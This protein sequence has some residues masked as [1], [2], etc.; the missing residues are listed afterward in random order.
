MCSTN[1]LRGAPYACIQMQAQMNVK[2]F[3]SNFLLKVASACKAFY[4]VP[5]MMHGLSNVKRHVSLHPL[6][7][8]TQSWCMLMPSQRQMAHWRNSFLALT[9]PIFNLWETDATK[10]VCMRQHASF[11]STSP[12]GAN[13]HLPWSRCTS[14]NRLWMRPARLILLAPGKRCTYLCYFL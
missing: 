6:C 4:D 10:K 13:W 12:T 14:S 2:D 9:K 11:S 5:K 3:M 7:R 1:T 8:W